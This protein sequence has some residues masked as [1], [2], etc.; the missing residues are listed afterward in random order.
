MKRMMSKKSHSWWWDSHISPKNSKWLAENL[1]EMD[2]RVKS[3][4]KLIDEEGDSFAKKAEMYYQR[5]PEL[6]AHVEDF[7]R[8]YRALAERY[9]H[10]TG[11]LRK[12]IQS[13]L[14]SQ[15]SGNVSD[16]GSEPPSPS[17]HSPELIPESKRSRPKAS[18]GK[19]AGFDFF[20]RSGGSSDVSRKESDPSS[21]SESSDSESE[22]ENGKEINEHDI[23]EGLNQRIV[24]LEN[25][26][27]D[28]KEKLQ[29]YEGSS[30]NGKCE[31]ME[32]DE[33]NSKISALEEELAVVSKRL[34]V[35]E[36]LIVTLKQ[37]LAQG[38]ASSEVEHVELDHERK[39]V[40]EMKERIAVLEAEVTDQ[41][42]VIEKLDGVIADANKKFEA[43]VTNRDHAIEGYKAEIA[44]A[45]ERFS[46]EKSHLE[47]DVA[48][49][50]GTIVNLRAELNKICASEV[51]ASSAAERFLQENS[52]LK[53]EIL[54]VSELRTALETKLITV[55][56]ELN[57]LKAEKAE[58]SVESEKQIENLYKSIYELNVKVEILMSVKEN[59]AAKLIV[60]SKDLQCRDERIIELNNHLH[61][62]HL[63]HVKLIKE[64]E[65]AQKTSLELRGKVKELEEEVDKQ[66]LAVL[67]GAE[68]K[69]EAIRQL[70]FS[71]EHY[72]DGYKQ[73][74]QVIQGH[75][76][77]TVMAV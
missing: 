67:D 4:L 57:L 48:K 38:N 5:R 45:S 73:L 19:A 3:M 12:N 34:R 44:N 8:M 69:R 2:K 70:C 60:F 9:D 49:L 28:V 53:E 36:A 58:A 20:L 46:Q 27:H 22:S 24:D 66:K 29:E 14:Q 23:T 35:S 13:E 30:V 50:T 33:Y 56:G 65:E 55:E 75:K 21:S 1:E 18:P 68:G 26:L 76:R 64:I 71:L 40:L 15:G 52:S 10:V 11:E 54:H 25:E 63:E 43:E 16:I 37:K 31:H 62:L 72:R 47:A 42:K 39:Q 32:I 59:L 17:V 74:R 61:D 6:V 41:K 77:H 7:Y 51:S